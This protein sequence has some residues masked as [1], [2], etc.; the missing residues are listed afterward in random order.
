M[1][2]CYYRRN[3]NN[4]MQVRAAIQVFVVQERQ[5]LKVIFNQAVFKTQF[6]YTLQHSLRR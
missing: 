5:S 4:E 6:E 3:V 2:S 1:Y